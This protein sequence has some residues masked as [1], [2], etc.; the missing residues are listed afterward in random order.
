MRV[1][2][3]LWKS[4]KDPKTNNLRSFFALLQKVDPYMGFYVVAGEIS[5][6]PLLSPC[7]PWTTHSIQ[8]RIESVQAANLEPWT[9]SRDKLYDIGSGEVE[10]EDPGHHAV[11][12]RVDAYLNELNVLSTTQRSHLVSKT[13]IEQ[14]KGV[15]H[16]IWN[17]AEAILQEIQKAA[18]LPLERQRKGEFD[19]RV[20]ALGTLIA[21]II[22]M[23]DNNNDFMLPCVDLLG[24]EMFPQ[25]VL[26]SN[27]LAA[28]AQFYHGWLASC[29][30]HD[31][32]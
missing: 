2:A 32:S 22:R 13:L 23:I 14:P 19:G 21:N 30:S 25:I 7:N 1:C 10:H 15:F 5:S 28:I 27:E 4:I 17:S 8:R 29:M 26:L 16:P 3:R 31:H 18:D 12:R 20:E 24:D 6:Q 11:Q 9:E